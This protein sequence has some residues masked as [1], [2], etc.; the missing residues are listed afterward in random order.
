MVNTIAKALWVLGVAAILTACGAQQ[1]PVN[2][3]VG[4]VP[5][6][7]SAARGVRAKSWMLA[8]AKT[9][10]LIYV[11]DISK[12]EVYA[13]SYRTGKMVGALS[14]PSETA[15]LCS[16]ARGNV[17][18]TGNEEIV[19]Y[20]HGGTTPIAQLSYSGAEFANCSIDRKT[21]NIAATMFGQ[22]SVAIF[23]SGSSDPVIVQTNRGL[24]GACAY[25]TKGDLFVDEA[26]SYYGISLE[27]LRARTASFVTVGTNV[28][29]SFGPLQWHDGSLLVNVPNIQQFRVSGQHAAQVG[30]V[31][32]A[33][34]G[35]FRDLSDDQFVVQDGVA[36]ATF[37][38]NPQRPTA[39]LLGFWKYPSGTFIKAFGGM[40][41]G[42][43]YGVAISSH[44]S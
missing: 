25:D 11:S 20:A 22:R 3:S 18:V 12:N 8:E 13:I 33:G 30:V 14:G 4:N 24:V 15:G 21:G 38:L 27:E 1:L 6:D 7:G 19:E 41:D 40:E 34:G 43:L 31:Q 26:D 44:S 23:S 36:I 17:Y 32:L 42:C 29:S 35:S 39:F 16:D 28:G 37:G 10:K 9:E 5:A 2:P